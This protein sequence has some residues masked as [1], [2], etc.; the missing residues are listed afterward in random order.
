MK[1]SQIH[2]NEEIL[3]KIEDLKQREKVEENKNDEN[4][5][6]LINNII[7]LDLFN[8][9]KSKVTKTV[10]DIDEDISYYDLEKLST[11]TVYLDE[12]DDMNYW[13]ISQ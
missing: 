7:N 8:K 4:D 11:N 12:T 1:Q 9:K 3:N 2:N 13:N 10:F 6:N 5:E